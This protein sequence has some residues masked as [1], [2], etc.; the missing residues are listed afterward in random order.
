[1]MTGRAAI[2][3]QMQAIQINELGGPEVLEVAEVDAPVPG[4]RQVLA[5]VAFAGVNYMDIGQARGSRGTPPPFIPGAEG[6]GRVLAIGS[7]V[8]DVAVGERIV[9]KLAPASYAEQVVVD[10]DQVVPVP[11]GV[12]DDVAAAVLL[13]GLTAQYLVNDSFA[14]QAGDVALVHAAAGGVGLLLTQLAR[15]RGATV[16]ATVS[17]E[18]K[19]KLARRAGADHVIRYDEVDFAPVVAELTAGAGV[20]VVYDAV[21]QATFDGSLASVAP[22]GRLVIYGASSG[23]VPP[24][25][26]TRLTG[27]RSLVRPSLGD[28]TATREELLR[29]AAELFAAITSGQLDV[30]IGARFPLADARLA[31][32]ALGA[33]STTGKVLLVAV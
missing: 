17:S 24:F 30:H 14:L 13:Q 4:P 26:I 25:D 6:S 32:E 27:S 33:R 5:A 18:A 15:R 21:G 22:H 8:E 20:S 11:D 1:M 31:H 29:R 3:A 12:G 16:I 7:D 28:F 2:G 23:R 19:A 9:W 10:L